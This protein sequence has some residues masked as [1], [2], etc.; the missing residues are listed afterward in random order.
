[1]VSAGI[2]IPADTLTKIPPLPNYTMKLAYLFISC[3][4]V[5]ACSKDKI[6]PGPDFRLE[7]ISIGGE[8]NLEYYSQ[9]DP[10]ITIILRFSDK[11]DINTINS[12]ISILDKNRTRVP[13]TIDVKNNP[14]ISI[15]ATLL[16]FSDYQL[17]INT[18][19]KSEKEVSIFTGKSY[20]IETGMDMSDKFPRITDDQLLDL[21][22]RNTCK[23]F[24]EFGHP[25]SGMARERTTSANTVTTGGTGFGIMSMIAVINRGFISRNEGLNRIR[26]IVSFLDTKCTKYHGAFSHWINGETGVTIPFSTDDNGGD[27]VETAL[28]FQGLLSARNYFNEN[29]PAENQLREDITRLWRGIEWSWYRKNN[30]NVLYW[31]WSMDK[32]WVKNL[33]IAGWNE[34]LIV[35]ILGASSPTYPIDKVV[36]D[37]GWARNG[38]LKNGKKFYSFLLPLGNDYGGPLFFS[39]YSFLGIDPR[40][41]SDNYADYWEQ[42]R[43]HALI[44]YNYCVENPKGYKGYNSDCW[45]LTACDGDTGYS[46][47]S[48]S[49]DKGV[50]APTAAISSLPYTPEESMRALRF[51]FYKLGDKIWG[52]YGFADAFNLSANWFDNQQIAIDQGPIVVMIENYRSALLWNLLMSDPDIKSGLNRLGFRY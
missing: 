5:F 10:K 38:S 7:E 44:N 15:G 48:P 33:K 43:N 24:I 42:N 32:G 2:M 20:S 12:N 6:T 1:M 31:H 50:I 18:G 25:V 22:Q 36:Y 39:H 41:L 49:N 3:I 51:F 8:K 40:N 17:I 16:S 23:Y 47:F 21:V 27:L 14:E 4:V 11:A 9:I 28:L 46:A 30:E 34:A 13:I 45:G 35:Y 26:Q 37:E 52:E 29:N 19:L